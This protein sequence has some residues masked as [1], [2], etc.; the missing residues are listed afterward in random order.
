MHLAASDAGGV[1]R[2]VRW[3]WQWLGNALWPLP[4]LAILLAIGLGIGLPALDEILQQPG[5]E[6]PLTLVFG[7]G[8]SAARDVL[9]AI[10]GSLISVTGLT[11][12]FTV[13]ALQLSSSQHSPRL[14]QTFV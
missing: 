8:P 2:G 5:G 12:S 9:A 4:V 1:R 14:L 11:F 10:A 7:G 13:V 3:A 6:H